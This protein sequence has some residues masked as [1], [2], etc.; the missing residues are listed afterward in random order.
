MVL[1]LAPNTP[2]QVDELLQLTEAD[3]A[4]FLRLDAHED[5]KHLG[6]VLAQ[7]CQFLEV[8]FREGEDVFF[9]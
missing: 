4:D 5:N 9:C 3:H 8:E 6:A 2:P 7:V 1:L